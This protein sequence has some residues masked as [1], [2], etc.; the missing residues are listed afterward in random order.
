[1]F[2]LA[3][4]P[5]NPNPCLHGTKCAQ[6]S[7]TTYRC[8]CQG[9]YYTGKNCELRIID[10]DE[11]IVLLNSI[12]KGQNLTLITETKQELLTLKVI[13]S[14]EFLNVSPQEVT[15]TASTNEV[16]F[17]VKSTKPGSYN[18]SFQFKNKS[19]FSKAFSLPEIILVFVTDANKTSS[20][21]NSVDE[22]GL[23][24]A[25]CYALELNGFTF[26]SN[27]PFVDNATDGVIQVQ[28]SKNGIYNN[29][30]LNLPLSISGGSFKSDGT[31]TSNPL[32]S[33]ID[34]GLQSLNNKTSDCFKGQDKINYTSEITT[35][36]AF[37][38]TI[39]DIWNKNAPYW[40][41]INAPIS[42]S[43]INDD[44][45]ASIVKGKDVHPDCLKNLEVDDEK[46]YYQYATNQPLE[47]VASSGITTLDTTI[48]KCFL[49]S[50]DQE[51]MAF[52]V[53]PLKKNVK[54]KHH[55]S[56]K[57]LLRFLQHSDNFEIDQIGLRRRRGTTLDPLAMND[58][59]TS[60]T[61][62]FR[63]SAAIANNNNNTYQLEI[64]IDGIQLW[65]EIV[66][67]KV[68]TFKMET[69]GKVEAV[70]RLPTANSN[71]PFVVHLS[72][73]LLRAARTNKTIK[74]DFQNLKD[75]KVEN[76][77][78]FLFF[79]PESK[80]ELQVEYVNQTGEHS[81]NVPSWLNYRSLV[82][83]L[84]EAASDIERSSP[85]I[86]LPLSKK[87]AILV[88]MKS[89]TIEDVTA[90]FHKYL[91]VRRTIW[92]IL[93]RLT[94][95]HPAYK[96][97]L[98]L[99]RITE[100]A[101]DALGKDLLVFE[102]TSA[103]LNRASIKGVGK[104]CLTDAYCL[105]P[106]NFTVVFDQT[107]VDCDKSSGSLNT[108][109]KISG[110]FISPETIDGVISTPVGG[111]FD[112]C[113]VKDNLGS[114]YEMKSNDAIFEFYYVNA[115]RSL[116][117]IRRD[118]VTLNTP[119]F[120]LELLG[121]VTR[122]T[123]R[124]SL[125][126][127]LKG[128][129]S[130]IV[131][132][133]GKAV[134]GS[135]ST[136]IIKA[137]DGQLQELNQ[138]MILRERNLNK[139]G[140]EAKD[141][142]D[143]L[144]RSLQ[145]RSK[146]L[147]NYQSRLQSIKMNM[148]RLSKQKP[149]LTREIQEMLKT[150]N[151]L[152]DEFTKNCLPRDCSLY[153][154][155][156]G[157]VTKLCE[158]VLTKNIT[159]TICNYVP[160]TR[161]SKIIIRVK[162]N[163]TRIVWRQ[164]RICSAQCPV[165]FGYNGLFRVWG[166]YYRNNYFW[167]C[168]RRWYMEYV[169]VFVWKWHGRFVNITTHEL[170]CHHE[171]RQIN[172]SGKKTTICQVASECADLK[173]RN[174]TTDCLHNRTRCAQLKTA[175]LNSRNVNPRLEEKLNE[176][177]RISKLM[178][179]Y[180]IQLI[181]LE[182]IIGNLNTTI[183]ATNATLRR[184]QY[185]I[186][187]VN[188]YKKILELHQSREKSLIKSY[189]K[190]KDPLTVKEVFFQLQHQP[191]HTY[192]RQIQLS[193]LLDENVT[194]SAEIKQ[195]S[196][197]NFPFDFAAMDASLR[198]LATAIIQELTKRRRSRRSIDPP[199]SQDTPINK[200]DSRTNG[201]VK[202]CTWYS[203]YVIKFVL[204]FSEGLESELERYN[205][206]RV[207]RNRI[208]EEQQQLETLITNDLS[209][210]TDIDTSATLLASIKEQI[211]VDLHYDT[212][213]SLHQTFVEFMARSSEQYFSSYGCYEYI[214]CFTR[215]INTILLQLKSEMQTVQIKWTL[216]QFFMIKDKIFEII[217]TGC[218]HLDECKSRVDM[219]LKTLRNPELYTAY[220]GQSPTI[221]QNAAS[222]GSVLDLKVGESFNLTIVVESHFPV[223]IYWYFNEKV[224]PN[225]RKENVTKIAAKSDSGF[226][227][228]SVA[229]KFG[230][231]SCGAIQVNVYQKPVFHNDLSNSLRLLL[232]S[233]EIETQRLLCNASDAESIEW[234]YRGFSE[235]ASIK[236]SSDATLDLM[237]H[238]DQKHM[239]GKTGLSSGYYWCKA[240]NKL[241]SANSN[242]RPVFVS[243][244]EF[245]LPQIAFETKLS[246]RQ[247]DGVQ[248]QE[249]SARRRDTSTTKNSNNNVAHLASIL[250]ITEEQIISIQ[251]DE[252]RQ[253]ATFIIQ[254]NKIQ[255]SSDDTADG[256]DSKTWND[257]IAKFASERD[258]LMNIVQNFYKKALSPN[259]IQLT[260][261]G[262]D[263]QSKSYKV[264]A[265]SLAT[266][267]LPSRCANGMELIEN[268]FICGEL[269]FVVKVYS[270][271]IKCVVIIICNTLS[272]IS[273]CLSR[274]ARR[275]REVY[276]HHI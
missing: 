58:F 182:R 2:V 208:N 60:G 171:T 50:M 173:L 201:L 248:S 91:E 153:K 40:V 13:P 185:Q 189:T 30:S 221:V 20:T 111:Q 217:Y 273:G 206:S 123:A 102:D 150:T 186:D 24:K 256:G 157:I 192:P 121:T 66:F 142:F 79:E 216:N 33:I 241:F 5:C 179:L 172:V 34:T 17:H 132:I 148:T 25:G 74:I 108:F 178:E 254:G 245:A 223:T 82:T 134:N 149:N 267:P 176:T 37:S 270:L 76:P 259:G 274:G 265:D 26:I 147:E 112:V 63:A 249:H 93:S 188:R 167:Q 62:S 180:T 199:S 44:L 56:F 61:E 36:N 78:E 169:P 219:I 18:I 174:D 196:V 27:I 255:P 31:F 228:C 8:S 119:K 67:P 235:S 264:V 122:L 101:Q 107:G 86:Y 203:D 77:K 103:A 210:A 146:D 65:D 226:Y 276:Y 177:R 130:A 207:V 165:H 99:N 105:E 244:T 89:V 269:T 96:P 143:S 215:L 253:L 231:S 191:R 193:I 71:P 88:S 247:K 154:C 127:V 145:N 224:I 42:H 152:N 81:F 164:K 187:A 212:F 195:L 135:L 21:G 90:Q 41:K 261:T 236:V 52:S 137:V 57:K 12:G 114:A 80:V 162:T 136:K 272:K 35:T 53:T 260:A 234:M 85:D 220:C 194:D 239:T 159:A 116:L 4:G 202:D 22:T 38:F 98:E 151:K 268:G 138:S 161:Q 275:K 72:G 64:K 6:H 117:K 184:I 3:P 225:A 190:T 242:I 133:D 83:A 213:P 51:L 106:H 251:I 7:N 97:L 204:D 94:S 29:E 110:T 129:R 252:S 126:S 246:K 140:I 181:T 95:H 54:E 183:A 211:K 75:S 240:S 263:D 118:L 113:L 229:N 232:K 125:E 39:F 139:A 47:I 230:Q 175:I 59:F 55:E 237:Q 49:Q 155:I 11:G 115:K 198:K 262:D 266:K 48:K 87:L 32:T 68:G 70:L 197:T 141:A 19:N 222:N 14:N 163:Q 200:D 227:T 160:V 84:I 257:D 9:T 144:F 10:V 218:R 45:E 128:D 28:L 1:M 258:N 104:L 43:N 124:A 131:D 16:K 156:P 238:Q 205:K 168:R 109:T 214:D 233:P 158:K 209:F 271:R 92:I 166:G 73:E 46:L 69:G 100:M 15:F 120:K 250:N 243:S 170:R 23:L